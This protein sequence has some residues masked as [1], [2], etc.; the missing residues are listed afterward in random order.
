MSENREGLEKTGRLDRQW[1][2]SGNERETADQE[3]HGSSQEA[4]PKLPTRGVSRSQGRTC[5]GIPTAPS[6]QKCG[7][8]R[9]GVA[10]SEKSQ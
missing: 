3:L 10:A 5:H 8:G 6:Y 1:S 4:L 9:E 7:L 2:S